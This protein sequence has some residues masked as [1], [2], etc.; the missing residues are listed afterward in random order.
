MAANFVAI[1]SLTEWDFNLAVF[2]NYAL[3]PGTAFMLYLI[4]FCG[5]SNLN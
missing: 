5:E 1:F 3:D 2:L 4:G